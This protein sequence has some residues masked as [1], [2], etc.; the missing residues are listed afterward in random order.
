MDR[1]T[2]SCRRP[3]VIDIIVVAYRNDIFLLEIQARSISLYIDPSR[4]ANIYVCINDDD[5][6]CESVDKSWWGTLSNKVTVLPRNFFGIAD[7]LDGWESQQL[8]KLLLANQ[9]ESSWS[10]CLDSKTWFVNQLDWMKWFDEF[11]KV[12]LRSFPTIPVFRP[13]QIFVEQYFNIT[14]PQVIGPGGV[15]FMFHT[16]TVKSL[17]STIP[18]FFNFF[19]KHMKYPYLLTEFMLYSGF[20]K[21]RYGNHSTLYSQRQF[22]KFCNIADWQV[23]EFDKIWKLTE[24]PSLLTISIQERAYKHLSDQQF[25]T[26]INYLKSKNLLTVHDPIVQKLNTLR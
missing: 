17:V 21:Q 3:E 13:A 1:T 14:S 5:H 12:N 16:E 10:L 2:S 22:Y 7:S 4:I 9:A 26:W 23:S 20:V 15:P 11:G 24:D 25:D 6:F 19:C 18:D 8:Y